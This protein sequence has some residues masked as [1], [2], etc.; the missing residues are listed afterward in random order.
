MPVIPISSLRIATLDETLRH[1]DQA[2]LSVR[3][4]P[5]FVVMDMESYRYLR[6]CELVAALAESRQ[7]LAAGQFLQESPQDHLARLGDI[8]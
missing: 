2:F 3:G 7:A 6:E 8:A 4:R 1:S 5:D